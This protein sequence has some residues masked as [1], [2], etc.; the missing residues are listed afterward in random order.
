MARILIAKTSLDGHW[1]G[2]AVVTRALREA[3]FEVVYGGEL[4]ASEI[5][6][7]ASDEDVDLVGLN[8]GGRIEVVER[9]LE[10][11]AEAGVGDI[12][13]FVG[14]TLTPKGIQTLEARGIPC[15]MPGSAL[16]DIVSTAGDLIAGRQSM[17][18]ES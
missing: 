14:G 7:V 18:S 8:V 4:R 2:V 11:M 1:R 13:V 5:A 9:I 10:R 3:G 17:G 12:P 15:F 6:S 16:D